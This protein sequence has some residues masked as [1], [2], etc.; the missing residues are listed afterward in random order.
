MSAHEALRAAPPPLS[1]PD[2]WQPLEPLR[3]EGG[4]GSFVSGEAGN[5]RLRVAYFRRGDGRLVGRAW[6]GP[7]ALG[8]PGHA[9]GGAI[10]AVLDEAM[11]AAAWQAGLIGVAASLGTDFRRMLPLG[12]D[13]VLEAW[14]EEHHGRK[15]H[16]AGRLTGDDGTLFAEARALFVRLDPERDR[17][18][19]ERVA[20]ALGRDVEDVLAALRAGPR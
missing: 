12:T 7:G 4:R 2:D 18:M 17:G 8:P 14:V 10:A 11:G 5:P 1:V 20:H 6:F 15:V 13:A 19:L 9:H 3:I 16:T